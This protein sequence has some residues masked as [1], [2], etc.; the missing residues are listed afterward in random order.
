MRHPVFLGLRADKRA[1]DV[2][3][4]VEKPRGRK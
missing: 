3:R 2:T 4:E 1:E